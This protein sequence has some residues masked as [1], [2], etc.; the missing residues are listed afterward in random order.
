MLTSCKFKAKGET[1]MIGNL[2]PIG[3]VTLLHGISGCGKTMGIIKYLIHEKVKPVFIDFDHNNEI[4]A[5]DT[6]HLDGEMVVKYISSNKIILRDRVVIVDT[7]HLASSFLGSDKKLH[8]FIDTL[9][10]LGNTVIVLSHTNAFSGKADEP[11]VDIPWA[12]HVACKLRL[13]RKIQANG[14]KIY[15]EVEKLRGYKGDTFITN[16][17]RD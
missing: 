16:W 10:K 5:F 15:L 9:I 11:A 2:I 8:L 1:R 12:N 13:H 4:S 6:D 3:R 14:E 7:Y 17:M